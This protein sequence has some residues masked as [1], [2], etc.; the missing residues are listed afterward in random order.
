VI[1]QL[2]NLNFITRLEV[3]TG[4]RFS[5]FTT[6]EEFLNAAFQTLVGMRRNREAKN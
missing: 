4:I 6:G 3:V 2:V 5:N 1:Q